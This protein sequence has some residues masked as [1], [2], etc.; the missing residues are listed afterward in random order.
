MDWTQLVGLTAAVMTT[1]AF[2]PQVIKTVRTRSTGD[3]SL[4]MF[5]V[6]CVGIG[7]WITYG[8]LLGDLPL[9]LG[10][11]VTGVLAG[12]ILVYKLKYK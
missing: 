11:G 3:I 5:L 4:G 1:T 7:L 6:L 9:V 8:V 12:T 2:L 10:N